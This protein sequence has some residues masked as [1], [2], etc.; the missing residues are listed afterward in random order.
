MTGDTDRALTIH[1]LLELFRYASE[2]IIELGKT[3]F[4][5]QPQLGQVIRHHSADKAMARPLAA[6]HIFARL[7]VGH[8]LTGG[9]HKLLLGF[10]LPRQFRHLLDQPA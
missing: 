6:L 4:Q 8:L 2:Q 5:L 7:E 1:G 3:L 9:E 10:K